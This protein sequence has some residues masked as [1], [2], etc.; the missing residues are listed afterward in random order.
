MACGG[1]IVAAEP[2]HLS[3]KTSRRLSGPASNRACPAADPGTA[4]PAYFPTAAH[5]PRAVVGW[6]VTSRE[7]ADLA[8]MLIAVA[9]AVAVACHQGVKEALVVIEEDGAS[10]LM[11]FEG[12]RSA[13]CLK[14]L[15]VTQGGKLGLQRRANGPS[16]TCRGRFGGRHS[17][18]GGVT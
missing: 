8:K 4:L 11:H 16:S 7:S 2:P 18:L 9:V 13:S 1:G 15:I 3:S 6:R 10:V 5:T 17:C 14:S 12:Y